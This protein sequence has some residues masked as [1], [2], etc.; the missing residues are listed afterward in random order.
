MRSDNTRRCAVITNG[1][2][3]RAHS[4]DGT[5]QRGTPAGGCRRIIV[6]RA[7]AGVIGT[8]A[9][10]FH[11]PVF[12][13]VIAAGPVPTVAAAPRHHDA[14]AQPSL[15]VRSAAA[16][17]IGGSGDALVQLLLR[18]SALACALPW[19]RALI[20]DPIAVSRNR[21][22]IPSA[23]IVVDPKRKPA[24][25]YQHMAIHPYPVELES[26]MVLA[27][28][29]VLAVRPIRPE[30][31]EL[32]R[33]FVASLSEQTR[34]YR[35]FYRLHELTPAMLARFTQVDYDRELA[36]LA[37]PLT[38]KVRGMA[39]VGIARYI[40]NV[41]HESAE[42]AVVVADAWHGRGIATQLMKVLIA[43]A[44][45]KGLQRLVGTVLR[46]NQTMVQF[47]RGLGFTVYD[48]PEEDG[49]FTVELPLR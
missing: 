45:K 9:I 3:W 30:D 27:D 1:A 42:F 35:F 29:T 28:G 6:Q 39:I 12:G 41:D 25:G 5:R 4:A 36:L 48:D 16:A 46:A 38:R 32:E 19:I 24:P 22:E 14:A 17:G 7:T 44:K 10:A 15:G 47:T 26:Q 23:R 11:R 43:S 18:M 2:R 34:Y 13:P 49:Q 33:R 20:L 37:R 40:A 8:Y 31:A 21:L